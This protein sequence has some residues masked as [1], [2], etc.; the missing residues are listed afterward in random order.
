MIKSGEM[1]INIITLHVIM[2]NK[3]LRISFFF[4]SALSTEDKLEYNFY[5][6]ASG[7]LQFR[8]KAANDA[9]IALTTGPH[10]GEPMY[11]VKIIEK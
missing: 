2:Y 9:H 7:Q 4:P 11:E 1:Y 10:E 6:V 3:C 8:I 5:P